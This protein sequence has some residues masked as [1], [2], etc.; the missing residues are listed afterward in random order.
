MA[1]KYMGRY[2]V[3]LMIR[4]MQIIAT[5]RCHFTHIRM[6]GVNK[7]QKNVLVRT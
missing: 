2:S 7:K 6:A 3:S 5:I 1:T 4:E